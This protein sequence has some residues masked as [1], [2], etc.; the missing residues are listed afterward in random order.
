MRHE[1]QI[2][3]T[4]L[5]LAALGAALYGLIIT[6]TVFA[7][8]PRAFGGQYF[9][10]YNQYFLALRDGRFDLPMQVLR[11]EGHYTPDGAGYVYH[12]I[13]PLI[14]RA[15]LGWAVDLNTTPLIGLSIWLWA[16]VGSAF[17]HLTAHQVYAKY[18]N[19]ETNFSYIWPV[20]IGAAAWLASPGIL[21]V[22]NR[23]LTHE[24]ITLGYALTAGTLW[25]FLR[26]VLLGA[27]PLPAL[28]AMSVLA[29]LC[30]H[31]RPNVALGLYGAIALLGLWTLWQVRLRAVLPGIAVATILIGS[32]LG[33]LQLNDAKFGEG[34]HIH[35][36]FEE[37]DLQYGSTYWGL[38]P[39]DSPRAQ[40]FIEHG[41]FNAAR[42]PANLT[43]YLV[44]PPGTPL[45]NASRA[46]FERATAH[47]GH[48]RDEWAPGI[49]WLWAPWVLFALLGLTR[50]ATGPSQTRHIPALILIAAT[51]A[52]AL[53]MAS[54]G[55][56]TVRYRTE[57][58]PLIASLG[59][60]GLAHL[61]PMR[62]ARWQTGLLIG[63]VIFSAAIGLRTAG[64]YRTAYFKDFEWPQATCAKMVSNKGFSQDRIPDLCP[65]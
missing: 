13:G 1:R 29:G 28:I 49:V 34:G 63:A 38:E 44:D 21:L 31:A 61:A 19:L 57:L 17:Y 56:H 2:R 4:A 16:V 15:A 53:L 10:I 42:I 51:S 22:A 52:M 46:W 60:I 54:Y 26:V 23:A 11:N 64:Q 18:A 35:G 12:G 50:H 40:A 39:V 62:P 37:G 58:W 36:G 8:S 24:T 32:G 45:Q 5:F 25:L 43:L 30:V 7:G 3:L 14:T 6:D 48:I 65:L 20:L 59:M 41:R 55:T 27:R 33:F 9:D 47:L